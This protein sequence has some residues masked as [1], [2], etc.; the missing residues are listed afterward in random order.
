MCINIV[1]EI[2]GSVINCIVFKSG[3]LKILFLSLG[4]GIGFWVIYLFY[5]V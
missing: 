1:K 4:I 5:L 2:C 3:I